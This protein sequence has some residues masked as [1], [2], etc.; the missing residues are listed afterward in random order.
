MMGRPMLRAKILGSTAEGWFGR[1]LRDI[2]DADLWRWTLCVEAARQ[3]E[4][5][6]RKRR[7]G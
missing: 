4:A 3:I 2:P 6:L 5:K 1:P 7:G